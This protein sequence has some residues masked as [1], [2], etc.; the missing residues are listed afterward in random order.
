MLI[1]IIYFYHNDIISQT[2]LGKIY[3]KG[4]FI[5]FSY[6]RKLIEFLDKTSPGLKIIY[7]ILSIAILFLLSSIFIF[8]EKSKENIIFSTSGFNWV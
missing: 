6:C 2:P 1:G 5:P 4:Q 3:F 7:V 8:Y